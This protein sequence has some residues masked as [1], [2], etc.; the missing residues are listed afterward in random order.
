MKYHCVPELQN[1]KISWIKEVTICAFVMVVNTPRLCYDVAFLPPM[2]TRAY[3]ISCQL[4]ADSVATE[5]L[6][7]GNRQL[8]AE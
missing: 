6:L 5:H 7:L 1:D 8:D 2:E 4:I 3:P